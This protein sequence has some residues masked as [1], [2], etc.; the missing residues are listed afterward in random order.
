[1]R[2]REFI[3]GLGGLAV[4]SPFAAH[5]QGNLPVVGWLSAQAL[6]SGALGVSQGFVEGLRDAGFVEG[7]NVIID[8]RF[9][10]GDYG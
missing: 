10:D 4:A 3:A 6:G 2:R 8:R 9:A 5:A 1:M 7:R